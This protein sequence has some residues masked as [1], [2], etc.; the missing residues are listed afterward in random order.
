MNCVTDGQPASGPDAEH[1]LPGRRSR[2]AAPRLRD[3]RRRVRRPGRRLGIAD[4]HRER[5]RAPRRR[6]PTTACRWRD[7]DAE[8]GL[9]RHLGARRRSPSRCR[10]ARR[11]PRRRPPR[12][13]RGERPG[14]KRSTRCAN[15]SQPRASSKRGRTPT[16]SPD[17]CSATDTRPGHPVP[18]C[19]ESTEQVARR[20]PSTKWRVRSYSRRNSVGS[21]A[22]SA[23]WPRSGTEMHDQI[24]KEVQH[25]A[26]GRA[27]GSP[28]RT[29]R[30]RL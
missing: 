30:R 4:E 7:E 24:G 21:H 6:R 28:A 10:R 3:R 11:G 18:H 13:A 20:G 17:T 19:T 15:F 25:R 29:F 5:S 9:E 16:V 14:A 22:C 23:R 1:E 2:S 12:P 26:C 8:P 27:T